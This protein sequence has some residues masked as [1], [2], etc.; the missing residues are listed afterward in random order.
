[1]AWF[2]KE[3]SEPSYLNNEQEFVRSASR[4]QRQAF[5]RENEARFWSSFVNRYKWETW[6]NLSFMDK[7]RREPDLLKKY[8]VARRGIIGDTRKSLWTLRTE[9]AMER[10]T[11]SS[12]AN[13]KMVLGIAKDLNGRILEWG[14]FG[15]IFGGPRRQQWLT[16][17]E[18]DYPQARGKL[19]P[20]IEWG[21]ENAAWDAAKSGNSRRFIN[22]MKK[23]GRPLGAQDEARVRQI[24]A[25]PSTIKDRQ[26]AIVETLLVWA[27]SYVLTGGIGILLGKVRT[28]IP[29]HKADLPSKEVI[30][31]SLHGEGAQEQAQAAHNEFWKESVQLRTAKWSIDKARR[32]YGKE[33]AYVLSA[34][35]EFWAQIDVNSNWV[36]SWIKKGRAKNLQRATEFGPW[37]TQKTLSSIRFRPGSP[38]EARRVSLL[39]KLNQTQV[40]RWLAESGSEGGYT[41]MLNMMN[42]CGSEEVFLDKYVLPSEENYGPNVKY[43]RQAIHAFYHGGYAP[44]RDETRDIPS[45]KY[46][47]GDQRII[48]SLV[49][50]KYTPGVVRMI[51]AYQ[52]NPE[53]WKA[54]NDKT[55]GGGRNVREKTQA[56]SK[57]LLKNVDMRSPEAV[58]QVFRNDSVNGESISDI[59]SRNLLRIGN[60]NITPDAIANAI[61]NGQYKHVN[62]QNTWR[63]QKNTWVKSFSWEAL[64]FT[65]RESSGI[66]RVCAIK[67][68]CTNLIIGEEIPSPENYLDNLPATVNFRMPLILTLKWGSGGKNNQKP[69]EPNNNPHGPHEPHV[70]PEGPGTSPATSNPAIGW[71]V[72]GVKPTQTTPYLPWEQPGASGVTPVAIGKAPLRPASP[73]VP[74]SPQG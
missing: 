48:Y 24:I 43:I 44:Y 31:Q 9:W 56:Y 23:V 1:M 34:I 29:L 14:L 59:Y 11:E 27:V 26:E 35:E 10:A 52:A 33:A 70:P 36:T 13:Q 20:L 63:N 65:V 32:L 53:K 58:S 60:I 57:D 69:H 55:T 16:E 45:Y 61:R 42:G 38:E 68:D 72:P 21:F 7:L 6:Q 74:A 4:S 54:T 2:K 62:G 49:H 30:T 41:Q 47:Q 51:N 18:N 39:E 25:A 8:E 3:S 50:S 71:E 17:I 5:L 73:Q 22:F 67:R 46:Q 28:P 19:L 64:V 15:V 66:Y 40:V 37:D 12:K